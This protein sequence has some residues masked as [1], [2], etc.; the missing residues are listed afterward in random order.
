LSF[1]KY[2]IIANIIENNTMRSQPHN[3]L[4]IFQ[5]KRNESRIHNLFLSFNTGI[6]I[7]FVFLLG[8]FVNPA[9]S[10]SIGGKSYITTRN[11][12]G[13]FQL[14]VSGYSAPL[15]VGS[16]D[17]WGVKHALKNLRSDITK[18]TN[19]EPMLKIGKL[20]K[21]KEMVVVGTI[22]RSGLIDKLMR[23]H[24]INV[25]SIK[26]KWESFI[27]QVVN[28]PYP[29]VDRALVIVGSDMLGT[30]YG[31]YDVS[32]KIGVSPWYWWDNVTP[33]HH[34]SLY[35]KAGTFEEGP[36]SVKY[37]GI[38]LNDEAPDLTNWVHN[39]YGNVKPGKNPPIPRGVA[40][41]GHKFYEHVFDL[42]LRLKANYLWPAMW[43]NAF[44]ED[45][46]LNPVMA[47]KYGI[48]MGTSHQEPMMR[49]QKEWDRRYGKT[50]GSWNFAKYP[51]TLTNFWKRGIERNK[52]Y[53][54]IVTIGLRG[55]NDSPMIPGG[56]LTQDTTLLG[57][58]VKEQEKILGNEMNS[59]VAQIPQL[60]CPYKEV[61]KYYNAGFRVPPYVTILWTDDNWG[62][63][64][65]LPTATERKRSGGAGIYYHFDYHGGPRSYQW[66]NANPLPKIWDQMSLADKYGAN[67]IW[68]VNVGHLK[69][70][71][72]PISY[73]MNLAWNTNRWTSNNINQFARLWARQQFGPK[74]ANEIADIMMKYSRYNGR[75]KPELLRPNTYSIVNYNEAAN[76][77]GEYKSI[78]HKAEKIYEKLPDDKQAAFYQLV[79]FPVKAC[80]ILNDMYYSA[81]RNE[82]YAKQK[83][84]MTN[85][86]ATKTRK[87]FRAD[88]SMMGYFNHSFK[89]GE[90]N[91]FMDQPFIGYKSWHE[92]RK[93]NLNAIHLVDNL[94]IPDSALMG[95]ALQGSREAWP[96]AS[97]DV[98][99]PQFD[100]YNRQTYYLDI[101]N[102]GK[103]P[104]EYTV[105]SG[106]SYVKVS[107][108]KGEVKRQHRIYVSINWKRAP[109]GSHRVPITITQKGTRN[110]VIVY[111]P[112]SNPSYPKR[113]NVKGF[114]EGDGYVSMAAAHYTKQ[115]NTGRDK[116]IRIQD[117][118]RTQ[119]GMR[120]VSPLNTPSA[121]PG[122]NAPCLEYKMYLFHTGE[123]DVKGIF[124]P[125]MNFSPKRGVRYAISFDN[126]S[127]KVVTLVPKKYN[128]GNGNHKWA[129]TVTDNVCYSSTSWTLKKTGFHTLKIWMVD[130]DVVLEKLVVNCGGVRKSYLGPPES[131]HHDVQND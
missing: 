16:G 103:I 38:F 30:V 49:A 58:I 118:G 120:S 45:D 55:E 79:L 124:G 59:D 123:V 24:K 40:N 74:Y 4:N 87:L 62:N 14:S 90:W 65:R 121:V 60:W 51:D 101:F 27:I 6:V 106:K 32:E 130:P 44:N 43:N 81:G 116:W 84:A 108:E 37:R 8:F 31:I 110:S 86:M 15:C 128:A 72:F 19:T 56:T 25:N 119:S 113:N 114:V 78:T 35:V 10:Q 125:T 42:L 50:L 54:E 66:I 99:L 63:L 12:R 91:G 13:R 76:V 111:A 80:Y 82:L 46:S 5:Q 112:V 9:R 11:G 52:N 107:S 92:P 109:E 23:E 61:L 26:G 29:G 89:G 41:Y 105:H 69:G 77:I 127:P 115:T 98:V 126:Q 122:K 22:G 75:R 34:K 33:Q 129:K 102:R 36:P 7:I 47:N 53:R 57:K 18:V 70:Y 117:Y 48:Y 20:P 28:H 64:R 96:S 68:I 93:N 104:F 21:S 95:V 83:R 71:A 2:G 39:K 73:F 131:F 17:Y 97:S 85:K 1:L 94:S 3:L 100:K 67:R 88:T